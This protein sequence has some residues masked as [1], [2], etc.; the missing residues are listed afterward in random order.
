MEN[1]EEKYFTFDII[2]VSLNLVDG[3]SVQAGKRPMIICQNNIG[4]QYSPTL[5][6]MALTTKLKKQN[7]PTHEVIEP[8]SENGLDEE[9]MI[10]GEQIFTIDKKSVI[11]K[12]GSLSLKDEKEKVEKCYLANFFG[13][14]GVVVV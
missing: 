8:T 4:N 6:A 12:L 11:R 14:K 9:S 5:I 7:M 10:L 1:K 3:Y 2:E 13:G